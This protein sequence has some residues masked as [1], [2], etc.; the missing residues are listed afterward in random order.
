MSKNKNHSISV[1]ILSML[2]IVA[3]ILIGYNLKETPTVI[4]VETSE[5]K[6]YEVNRVEEVLRYIENQYVEE[7]DRAE[8]MEKVINRLL[9]ELDTVDQPQ[10]I[11][12]NLE[13]NLVAKRYEL[14]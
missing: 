9:E 14:L 4:K 1:L 12:E 5:K 3:G 10:V 7:I 6:S 11:N 2:F 13:G 8:L